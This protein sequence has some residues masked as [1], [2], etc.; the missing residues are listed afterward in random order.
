MCNVA[1]P[2]IDTKILEFDQHCT[3]DKAPFII[4]A[5][6]ESLIVKIDGSKN[7][8]EKSSTRPMNIFHHVYQCLENHHL[9]T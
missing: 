8:P 9:K 4:Y 6:L 5:D 1:I 2:S 3:S 7:D